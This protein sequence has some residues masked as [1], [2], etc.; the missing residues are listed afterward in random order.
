MKN[1]AIEKEKND[2]LDEHFHK[3]PYNVLLINLQI[4]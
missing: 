1:I 3:I 2:N 4:I